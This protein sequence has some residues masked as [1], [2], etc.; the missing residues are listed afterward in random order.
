MPQNVHSERT[1]PPLTDHITSTELASVGRFRHT[2]TVQTGPTFS[3]GSPIDLANETRRWRSLSVGEVVGMLYSVSRCSNRAASTREPSSA[4]PR[5][6]ESA[7]R[8]ALSACAMISASSSTQRDRY[9]QRSA[10]SVPAFHRSSEHFPGVGAPYLA[11]R[12]PH[13][14][15]RPR[16]LPLRHRHSQRSRPADLHLHRLRRRQRLARHRPA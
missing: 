7:I 14:A 13:S 16:Y 11:A 8:F 6:P 2:K 5:I 9:E 15:K 10:F 3:L 12:P 1:A 4:N